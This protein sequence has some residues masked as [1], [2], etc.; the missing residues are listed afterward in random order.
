MKAIIEIPDDLIQGACTAIRLTKP[1][2]APIAIMAGEKLRGV[3]SMTIK[4]DEEE[5]KKS[6]EANIAM[7][8]ITQVMGE[9][10]DG[11]ERN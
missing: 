8:C 10:I 11:Y 9:M 7:L 1:N 3:N 6:L 4:L 5:Q 2:L